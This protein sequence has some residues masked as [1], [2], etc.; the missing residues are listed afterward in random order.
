MT[1]SIGD[2]DAHEIGVISTPDFIEK[3]ILPEDKVIVVASDGLWEFLSNETVIEIVGK[4]FED[5]NPESACDNLISA[6]EEEWKKNDKDVDDI[7][8]IVVYLK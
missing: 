7:T 8:T 6:A 5:G 1:R 2:N 4:C 3:Q